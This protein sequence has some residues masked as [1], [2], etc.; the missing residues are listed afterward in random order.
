MLGEAGEVM[1]TII[2]ADNYVDDDN[3]GPA[4]KMEDAIRSIRPDLV[5]ASP[6]FDNELYGKSVIELMDCVKGVSDYPFVTAIY[7]DNPV[8][9]ELDEDSLRSGNQ[10]SFNDKRNAVFIIP[11]ENSEPKLE[12]PLK[13][14]A[15]LSKKILEG[16][17]IG[18]AIEEGY[19]DIVTD[20]GNNK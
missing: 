9:K 7:I 4:Y 15:R 8:I 6:V 1:G 3:V 19:F 16:E 2:T 12:E 5:V 10:Y 20:N 14:M 11:I 17:I 18:E 13:K